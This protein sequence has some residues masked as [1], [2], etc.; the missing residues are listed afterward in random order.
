MHITYINNNNITVVIQQLHIILTIQVKE[1]IHQTMINIIFNIHASI[2]HTSSFIHIK[3]FTKRFG[4]YPVLTINFD[5]VCLSFHNFKTTM[6]I[7]S[8]LRKKLNCLN[9]V[10]TLITYECSCVYMCVSPAKYN[11]IIKFTKFVS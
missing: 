2:I 1:K 4:S 10:Y 5:K 8:K 9:Y 7:E 6:A 11:G 3:L